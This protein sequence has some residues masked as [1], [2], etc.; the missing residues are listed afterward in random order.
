[1]VGKVIPDHI[2]VF[3]DNDEVVLELPPTVQ[4]LYSSQSTSVIARLFVSTFARTSHVM[5]LDTDL[6]PQLDTL[7]QFVDFAKEYP[8]SIL[9]HEGVILGSG[10]NPYT[11][12]V[13]HTVDKPEVCDVLIRSWF[14]PIEVFGSALQLYWK[15]G[16]P[17]KYSDDLI[18]CLANR[19]IEKQDNYIIPA[20]FDELDDGG[21]GQSKSIEHYIYRD[22]ICDHLLKKYRL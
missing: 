13:S 15:E 21:R 7:K 14:V 9:G 3:V 16:L 4:I 10:K 8:R 18:I 17:H 5:L 6:A 2:L 19:L 20:K 1:M 12:V 11:S 22:Q